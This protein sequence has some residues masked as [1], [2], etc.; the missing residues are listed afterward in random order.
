MS[1]R[2]EEK[3]L[4]NHNQIFEFKEYLFKN[5][6]KILFPERNIDSLY[7]DNFK[8]EMYKDSVEGI[9]PRKK[10]RIRQYPKNINKGLYLETKISSIE[11]RFKK[12][13]QIQSN[14]FII[15]KERG[16]FD[17]QYGICKPV[18]HVNY[19]R[20]YFQLNDV[21][22]VIDQHIKY[23]HFRKS[24]IE[25]DYSSI[26]EIKSNF[27]KNRD[28]LINNFPF[29]RIRFSKYCNGYNKL[30]NQNHK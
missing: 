28:D 9:T 22:I 13:D 17:P 21:R 11:G 19:Q 2:V 14:K 20:Q 27:N 29:Q 25:K 15:F 10:I 24:I 23:K 4:I 18:I 8:G 5:N 7:F 6:A 12:S 16:I 3:L 1:F 30:Y 26:I